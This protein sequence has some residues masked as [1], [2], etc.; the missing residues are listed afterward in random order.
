MNKKNKYIFLFLFFFFFIIRLPFLDNTF[1]L[2]DERDIILSGYSIAKT[3][4]DLYG[5][6]LPLRF[7]NISPSNPIGAIYFSAFWHLFFPKTVFFS[8]LAYVFISS[9]LL[10]LVYFLTFKI[11]ENKKISFLTALV[12]SFSP[13]IYHITRLALEIPLALT[14]LIAGIFFY[15]NKNF[16]FA[17]ILFFICS[18]TYQ[19]FKILI[20]FLLLYLEFFFFLTKDKNKYKI[21]SFRNLI[22]F[23][24][25]ITIVFLT[26]LIDKNTALNRKNEIIFLNQQQLK[27]IVDFKRASSKAPLNLSKYFDNK[28]TAVIDHLINGLTKNYD[29]SYLFKK[30]D[31]SAINGNISAGQFFQVFILFYFL[32]FLYLGKK[33]KKENLYIFG[34]TLIGVIPAIIKIDEEPSFSIRGSLSAFGFSYLLSLGV[35]YYLDLIKNKSFRHLFNIFILFFLI[36]NIISF[37]YN[38]FCRRPILISEIFNENERQL[39]NKLNENSNK[40]IKI[41]H[42][43]PKDLYLSLFFLKGKP[44]EVFLFQKNLKK[45]PPYEWKNY[46]FNFCQKNFNYLNE[47]NSIV[48]EGCLEPNEYQ[49]YEDKIITKIKYS[50]F[51]SAKTAYF[52]VE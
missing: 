4:K 11:I 25:I 36:T 27:K 22:N 33:L 49:K 23:I 6:F 7:E 28:L 34:F 47:K 42:N 31:S 41:Y 17:Y 32:G 8:R 44:E 2:H 46:I 39:I 45:G 18:F 9:F 13:W 19:G 26:F 1:L 21:I 5:N 35:I 37:S 15:L 14:L 40:K 30:G 16:I 12:F 43:N 3:G 10:I 50:D 24:F 51:Y 52:I 20:P 29:I 38:Y 48:F